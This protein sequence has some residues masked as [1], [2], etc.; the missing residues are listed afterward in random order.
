MPASTPLVE[1]A[2][3]LRRFRFPSKAF[4]TVHLS[5]ALLAGLGLETLVRGAPRRAVA[6]AWA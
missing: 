2:P 3:W 5:A 4:F 6:R 1:A